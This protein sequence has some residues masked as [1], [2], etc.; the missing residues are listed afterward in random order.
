M[1]LILTLWLLK[2]VTRGIY[3]GLWFLLWNLG[4]LGTC[5]HLP[6]PPWP[7]EAWREWLNHLER[8]GGLFLLL[9]GFFAARLLCHWALS[10]CQGTCLYHLLDLSDA[11]I[12]LPAEIPTS[13]SPT[14][15][16]HT[17]FRSAGWISMPFDGSS[18]NSSH[19][20]IDWS[21]F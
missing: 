5:L 12:C 18:L 10:V 6:G 3:L 15:S 1:V 8:E 11:A 16:P 13:H 4:F 20:L 21:S 9:M 7:T 14:H 19:S 17:W 2:L